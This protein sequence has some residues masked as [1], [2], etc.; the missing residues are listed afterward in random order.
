MKKYM[1][2][3]EELGL[4]VMYDMR[5]SRSTPRPTLTSGFTSLDLVEEQVKRFKDD[6]ALWVWYTADEPDGPSL[7]L[8][9]TIKARN[10]IRRLDPY[11]P[12]ALVFNCNDYYFEPYARG[13]DILLVDVYHIA[14]NT[15]WSKKW[16]TVVN[17][18]YG[19]GGCDE[20]VGNYADLSGRIDTWS[21]RLRIMRSTAPIWVVPQGFDDGGDEFWWRSPTGDEV[22]VQTVLGVIH[23]VKGHCAWHAESASE[24]IMQVSQTVRMS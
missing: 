10:L 17:S 16:S 24:D 14:V 20:C 18:T 12:V 19:C 13:A 1:R 9:S 6:P 15:A 7:P 8:D 11:H 21:K 3:A 4:G 22:V 5:H 23:G 2:H